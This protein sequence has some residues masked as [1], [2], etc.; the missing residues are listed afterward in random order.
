[1]SPPSC[2]QLIERVNNEGGEM[3]LSLHRLYRPFPRCGSITYTGTV[4]LDFLTGSV[5]PK[6]VTF[7]ME[8]HGRHL[9][10]PG[11]K[12]SIIRGIP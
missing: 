6:G 11:T 3:G 2:K 4:Q 7:I 1:M 10:R 9:L 5:V 12:V 8:K